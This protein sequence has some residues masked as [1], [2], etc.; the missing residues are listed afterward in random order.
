M[1]YFLDNFAIDTGDWACDLV[2]SG[3]D[4]VILIIKTLHEP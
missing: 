3:G 4:V 2:F 1:H